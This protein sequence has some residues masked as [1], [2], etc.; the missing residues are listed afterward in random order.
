MRKNL[1]SARCVSNPKLTLTVLLC[2]FGVVVLLAMAAYELA[3]VS[4]LV[5]VGIGVLALLAVAYFLYPQL[6]GGL[7]KPGGTNPNLS[8]Q[9]H[10]AQGSGQ[11][12]GKGSGK[13]RTQ[14][15]G[16]RGNRKNKPRF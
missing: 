16:A 1:L 13:G 7:V 14:G 9:E 3:A 11:A 15:Q 8:W 2:I 4:L 12:P 6:Y 5:I 10:R